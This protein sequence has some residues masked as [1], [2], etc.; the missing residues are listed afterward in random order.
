MSKRSSKI[1]KLGGGGS[2]EVLDA[3]PESD[4]PPPQPAPRTFTPSG[5]Y[6]FRVRVPGS[7]AE[8]YASQSAG[9]DI[10]DVMEQRLASCIDHTAEK[11]VYFDDEHRLR[12]E[13]LCNTNFID[14]RTDADKALQKIE[15]IISVSVAGINFNDIL[16]PRD[17]ERLRSRADA[18]R[19]T[20]EDYLKEAIIYGVRFQTGQL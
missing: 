5:T 16:T 10:E 15:Q 18:Y 9:C 17:I 3:T 4:V 14:P 20:F 2:G 8:R 11:P 7:V 1:N 12:L 19:R 6:S 13:Q